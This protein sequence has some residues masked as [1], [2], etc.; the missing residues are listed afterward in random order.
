MK[1]STPIDQHRGH[2]VVLEEFLLVIA[3]HH[4]DFRSDLG[5]YCAHLR[6][7]LLAGLITRLPG[8]WREFF[9]DGW[10]RRGEHLGVGVDASIWLPQIGIVLVPLPMVTPEFW[11][12][13][14]LRAVGCA[15]SQDDLCHSFTSLLSS[16]P[17]PRREGDRHI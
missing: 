16:S 4:Q 7:A 14:E 12:C 1:R 6:D 10:A 13:A 15:E 2:V 17:W 5:E 3:N 8:V 9:L 11:G